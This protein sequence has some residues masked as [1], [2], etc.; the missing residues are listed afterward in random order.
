M[1]DQ[2]TENFSEKRRGRPRSRS[3]DMYAGLFPELRSR[4]SVH[5]YHRMAL[6]CAVLRE[7][8]SP[9]ALAYFRVA[10]SPAMTPLVALS[11]LPPDALVRLA[12]RAAAERLSCA[13]VVRLARRE[14]DLVVLRLVDAEGAPR[15]DD[16]PRLTKNPRPRPPN[17]AVP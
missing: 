12:E 16:P 3:L 10:S 2:L 8:G 7:R 1:N 9:A 4:R 14:R 17:P 13:E 5:N 11:R 6:A 15:S